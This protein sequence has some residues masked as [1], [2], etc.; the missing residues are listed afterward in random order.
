MRKNLK[1]GPCRKSRKVAISSR[2]KPVSRT[3]E[4]MVRAGVTF[5]HSHIPAAGVVLRR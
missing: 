1:Y 2:Q 5:R 4:M 3:V